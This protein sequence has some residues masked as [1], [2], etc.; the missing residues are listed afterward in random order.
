[1]YYVKNQFNQFYIKAKNTKCSTSYLAA[2]G[3]CKDRTVEASKN[4]GLHG[5]RLKWQFTPVEGYPSKYA[6]TTIDIQGEQC[7]NKFLSVDSDSNSLA[8]T[9]EGSNSLANF[10]AQKCW[11]PKTK[12]NFPKCG[13]LRNLGKD[14]KVDYMALHKDCDHQTVHLVNKEDISTRD[15]EGNFYFQRVE[16]K[17][18]TF[19]VKVSPKIG[20]C[21]HKYL[22]VNPDCSFSYVQT[23][24][25]DDGTGV[26]EWYAEKVEDGKNFVTLQAITRDGC[27]NKYLATKEGETVLS[28][29]DDPEDVFSHF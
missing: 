6:I 26:T 29:S 25:K 5:D 27:P 8:L 19:R 20:Y 28:L 23:S 16:G 21:S 10:S 2:T 7:P 17:S 11:R 18:N 15:I 3:D 9:Q 12:I 13:R 1:M 4:R 22:S 24:E 14:D